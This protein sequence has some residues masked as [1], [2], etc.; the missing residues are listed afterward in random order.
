MEIRTYREVIDELKELTTSNE[1]E[2]ELKKKYSSCIDELE[3]INKNK[4]RQSKV[5]FLFLMVFSLFV[6]TFAI[7]TLTAKDNLQENV[8]Q[9]DQII[10]R[11]EKMVSPGKHSDVNEQYLDEHGKPI[12]TSS[13]IEENTNLMNKLDHAELKLKWI[14]HD[15]GIEVVENGNQYYIKADKVDSALMLLDVYR[16]KIKYNRRNKSWVIERTKIDT[17][18]SKH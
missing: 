18:L 7:I 2:S 10:N 12:T 11:Y 6:A 15:Y 4:E 5:L 17:V 9:K 3:L 14:K 8:G 16:D 1:E 13:L